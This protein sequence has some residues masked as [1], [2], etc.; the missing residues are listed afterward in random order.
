MI[1]CLYYGTYANFDAAVDDEWKSAHQLH[2]A[3]YALADRWDLAVLKDVALA[4]FSHYGST[5]QY[6]LE[7]L[8]S[9]P[10]VYSSTPDSNRCLRDVT[11]QKVTRAPHL[12]LREDIKES[13]QQAVAEVPDF[14]WDLHQYWMSPK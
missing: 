8:E 2:A 5:P 9:I 1:H 10:L 3:M 11:V 13:F 6:L 7:F 14:S 12:F 4:N